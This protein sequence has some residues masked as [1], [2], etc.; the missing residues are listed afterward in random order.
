MVFNIKVGTKKGKGLA[1]YIFRWR[2]DTVSEQYSFTTNSKTLNTCQERNMEAMI[3]K[4]IR[5]LG[6]LL[7]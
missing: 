1:I 7:T 2:K 5:E 3:N 4:V 6:V